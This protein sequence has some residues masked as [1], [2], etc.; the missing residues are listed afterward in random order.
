M[1]TGQPM[2]L[3]CRT[4]TDLN[5]AARDG[6]VLLVTADPNDESQHWFQYYDIVGKLTDDQGRRAFALVNRATGQAM[7]NKTSNV[8][9]VDYS[10]QRV[11]ISM[12]WSMGVKLPNGFS[13]VRMLTDTSCTLNVV[14]GWVQEDALIGLYSPEPHNDHAIW[15]IVPIN[16]E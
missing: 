10:D 4:D 7:V 12:M 9:L 8:C 11:E 1:E 6:R 14:N 5:A 13:E 3:Y 16:G 2:R 15:R